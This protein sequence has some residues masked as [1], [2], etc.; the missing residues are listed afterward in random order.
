MSTA[1]IRRRFPWACCSTAEAAAAEGGPESALSVP[2]TMRMLAQPDGG[3]TPWWE[4]G[5]ES[6]KCGGGT[7]ALT[8]AQG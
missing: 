8:A 3:D 1:E 6:S 2:S 5:Y 4:A 7:R